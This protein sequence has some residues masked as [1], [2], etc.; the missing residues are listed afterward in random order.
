MFHTAALSFL[1]RFGL[2][3]TERLRVR[4][5]EKVGWTFCFFSQRSAG[6]PRWFLPPQLPPSLRITTQ[7]VQHRKGAL[8]HRHLIECFR[9]DFATI[10]CNAVGGTSRSR[11]FRGRR[12]TT[13]QLWVCVAQLIKHEAQASIRVQISQTGGHA[14]RK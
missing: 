9:R 14:A 6:S 4:I 13:I 11:R 12:A 8:N 10:E 2:V 5:R 1:S 7:L 3:D